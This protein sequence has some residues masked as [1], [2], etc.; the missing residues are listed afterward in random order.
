MTVSP[1]ARQKDVFS[2]AGY[3][4]I[5]EV[6]KKIVHASNIDHPPDEWP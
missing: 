6:T 3:R 4:A 2:K 5:A 1:A